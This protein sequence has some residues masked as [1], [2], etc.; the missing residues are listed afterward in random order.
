MDNAVAARTAAVMDADCVAAA[1]A[2]TA[3]AGT[4]PVP[5]TPG[6][7]APV[8]GIAKS[9]AG[10]EDC[11]VGALVACAMAAAMSACAAAPVSAGDE[12]S[13]VVLPGAAALLSFE[14]GA[15]VAAAMFTLLAVPSM[16]AAPSAGLAT[17]ALDA[18]ATRAA[19]AE[20]PAAPPDKIVESGEADT[21]AA[22]GV[23][24]M[25]NPGGTLV[26]LA[27]WLPAAVK[28]SWAAAMVAGGSAVPAGGTVPADGVEPAATGC[29]LGP[30][31]GVVPGAAT[32]P[33]LPAWIAGA[34]AVGGG[35]GV[36]A[37]GG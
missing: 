28:L 9:S 21:A 15:D 32:A 14:V 18:A 36:A 12:P 11:V 6:G 2:A 17:R 20:A 5:E 13:G 29:P 1:A 37:S 34:A 26:P 4:A 8:S 3:R 31:L 16:G 22:S 35:G 27:A 10:G 30:A 19:G 24:V 33:V 23:D 7:A 25:E